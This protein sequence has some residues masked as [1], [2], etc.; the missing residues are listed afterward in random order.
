MKFTALD[1]RIWIKGLT[2]ECPLGQAIDECP[3]NALRHLPVVQLNDTING[4]TD[5]QVNAIVN[6][7]H[8]CYHDRIKE[9]KHAN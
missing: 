4:L 5:M 9:L 6:I 3:L 1:K 8:H 2:L 7:H